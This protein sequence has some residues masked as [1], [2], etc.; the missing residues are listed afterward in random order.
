MLSYRFDASGKFQP[1]RVTQSK[2]KTVDEHNSAY[3]CAVCQHLI[4][5]GGSAIR[6]EGEHSH[7][8]VNP[9]GRKFLLRCF[10]SAV[11]CAMSGDPTP[12]F[13]WFAGYKWQFAH[14]SE[15]G[16][17]MGWFYEGQSKFYGLIKEQLIRCDN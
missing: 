3:C 10:S 2:H 17:Q 7:I 11:G 13:S 5:S 4:T 1:K 15:C 6:V 8:K 12:N 14:C 16:A 9:D